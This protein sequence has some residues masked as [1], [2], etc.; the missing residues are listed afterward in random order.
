[1]NPGDQYYVLGNDGVKHGP[2]DV[3]TLR[4]W[5]NEG[6]LLANSLVFDSR[7]NEYTASQVLP[8]LFGS[9]STVQ[10]VQ[11]QI[12][13]NPGM[14]PNSGFGQNIQQGPSIHQSP[15]GPPAP[16]TYTPPPMN[17]YDD[18]FQQNPSNMGIG[19]YG[20]RSWFGGNQGMGMG[21]WGGGW[22]GYG[23]GGGMMDGLGW[24]MALLFCCNIFFAIFAVFFAHRAFLAKFPLA[25]LMIAVSYF[26]LTAQ[27]G[28]S[29]FWKIHQ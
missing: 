29:I 3:A 20:R 24:L 12:N 9:H 18:P 27:L 1:M 26:N 16:G 25:K 19:G 5:A 6:R 13:Q 8:Q 10:Q 15:D 28:Y 14:N 2:A 7:G 22:G 17:P 4:T 21:G 11:P 23:G